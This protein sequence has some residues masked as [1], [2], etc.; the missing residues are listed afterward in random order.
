[1][2]RK[3]TTRRSEFVY[4]LVYFI[5]RPLR[6]SLI[7]FN[8]KMLICSFETCVSKYNRQTLI[9]DLNEVTEP[10][11]VEDEVTGKK[12]QESTTPQQTQ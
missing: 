6:F 12:P 1:M 9:V 10:L 4:S 3:E 8:K 11:V 2:R 7:F 5:K